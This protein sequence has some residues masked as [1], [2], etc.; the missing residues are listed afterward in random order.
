MLCHDMKLD[1]RDVQ[2]A[3]MLRRV[4]ELKLASDTTRLFRRECLVERSFDVRV[5]V[6]HHKNDFLLV[7]IDVVCQIT[8]LFCPILGRPMLAN[9]H[10]VDAGQRF[11]ECEDAACPVTNIR[12]R[13]TR[14]RIPPGQIS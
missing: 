5:E 1:F 11:D 4:V 2:P 8:N 9:A 12:K 13:L 10:V 6:V 7:R 3:A 14:R